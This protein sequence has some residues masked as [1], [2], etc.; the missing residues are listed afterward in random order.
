MDQLSL[1]RISANKPIFPRQMHFGATVS[2][3]KTHGTPGEG[4]WQRFPCPDEPASPEIR[5]DSPK[6][7]YRREFL[8]RKPLQPFLQAGNFN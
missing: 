8:S 3:L 4:P 1:E 5:T 6:S 7:G 2:T